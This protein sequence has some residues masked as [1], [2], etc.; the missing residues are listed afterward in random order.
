MAQSSLFQQGQLLNAT[1][2]HPEIVIQSSASF[3][4]LKP[5]LKPPLCIIG[6]KTGKK[7][8]QGTD[9]RIRPPRPDHSGTEADKGSCNRSRHLIPRAAFERSASLLFADATPLL[10]KERHGSL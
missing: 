4:L 8:A 6:Q 2:I 7:T 5:C 9:N 1:E 3:A 10:E